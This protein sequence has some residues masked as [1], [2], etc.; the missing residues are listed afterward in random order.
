MIEGSFESRIEEDE[1]WWRTVLTKS[2]KTT[3]QYL[4][5]DQSNFADIVTTYNDQ[6]N[7]LRIS[8][9]T[10]EEVKREKARSI[11]ILK[12]SAYYDNKQE[13]A[14]LMDKY[15]GLLNEDNYN[16]FL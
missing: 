15:S 10:V 6:E 13:A 14:E 8:N 4:S 1:R 7:Y 9:M 5:A 2:P 16:Q 11:A 3:H 12:L